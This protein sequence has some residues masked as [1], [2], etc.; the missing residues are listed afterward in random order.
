MPRVVDE[1]SGGSTIPWDQ[2]GTTCALPRKVLT[3]PPLHD[4]H[5]YWLSAKLSGVARISS[6]L[7]ESE[8]RLK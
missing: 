8:N 2:E 5:N 6:C 1:V 3:V 4:H 7:I